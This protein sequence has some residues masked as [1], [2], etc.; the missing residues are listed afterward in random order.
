MKYD[1]PGKAVAFS[2]ATRRALL[3]LLC[4]MFAG[5]TITSAQPAATGASQPAAAPRPKIGLVLSGGGARGLAH[6]GVLKELE[7]AR[8]PI[9]YV[10]GTS[11]GSIVGGLYAS[12]MTPAE[13]ERRIL[14]MEWDSMFA[15]RPP[16]DQL[17]L[18]RKEDDLRLSIPL[19]F[20]MRDGGLRAPRA[21]VGSSGLEAMLKR[22]TEGVPGD[23]KFD[24]MPIPFRA[25]ATDL[26]SG[27]AVVFEHG[28]LAAVMRASMSVPAAFAPVEIGGR[29]LVDGGLVDNLPVDVVRR[30]GADI[31]IAVN[32]GTPLLPREELGSI[33]GIGMQMLNILTEQNVRASIASLKASDVLIVPDLAKVT[34]VD[35]KLGRDAIA[36]GAE[37]TRGVL[38]LLSNYA[39]APTDYVKQLAVQRRVAVPSRI[40]EVR[41]EGTEYTTADVIRAQLSVLPGAP[42]SRGQIEQDLAWLQ[43]RGDFERLDYRLVTER[44]RNV[45][46]VNVQEKPWG[47]NYF[48]FGLN[49]GTDF[50]GEGAFNLIGNHTRRWLNSYG[51]EWRNEL[52]IGRTQRLSTELYQPLLANETLFVSAGAERERRIAEVGLQL[53]DGTTSRPLLQYA[54]VDTRVWLDLGAAFGRYGELRIGPHYERVS[55]SPKISPLQLTGIKSIDSGFHI[56]AVIDQR[57]AAAFARAGYRVEASLL[58]SLTSFGASSTFSRYQWSSEYAHTYGANTVDLA[59]KF[60]GLYSKAPSAYPYFELGGF[61]QLSGLRAAEMRGDQVALARA[62]AFRKIGNMPAFGRGI[63]VGGSLEVGRIDSPNNDF[64]LERSLFGGSLFLGLDTSLGPLYVGYGHATGNRRSAYLMLGRP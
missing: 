26:V 36:R 54:G 60:G 27:E 14:A 7:A 58:R 15:D 6:V 3:A 10:A 5:V 51:G 32:I 56:N 57:D 55:I 39:L 37:A 62:M 52:Q 11:M 13:L 59:L 25:V 9:D 8:I 44:D 47:P 64:T 50:R 2:S 33:F 18:R 43:G 21:A 29:L 40:D 46:L 28:E 12:G 61:L 19:E 23:V 41:I 38:P 16:R 35:F 48:R 17:S 42:F 1:I 20:G 4:G 22:L 63:Y 49:L 30:M 34:S 31:V 53:A 24:R 45:L